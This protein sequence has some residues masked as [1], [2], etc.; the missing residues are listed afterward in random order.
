VLTHVVRKWAKSSYE[1]SGENSASYY[2]GVYAV[3]RLL[4]AVL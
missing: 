4:L 2:I 1:R 3:V